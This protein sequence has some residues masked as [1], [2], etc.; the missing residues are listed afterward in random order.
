MLTSRRFPNDVIIE[1][2]MPKEAELNIKVAYPHYFAEIIQFGF[3]LNFLEII[4][5]TIRQR[6]DLQTFQIWM[7]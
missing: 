5:L 6:E 7:E 1:T 4:N 3:Y 2:V